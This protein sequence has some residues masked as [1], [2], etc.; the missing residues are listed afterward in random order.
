GIG[1]ST[2]DQAAEAAA[3][4]DGVIVGT[5]VVRRQLAGAGPDGVAAFVAELRAGLD[6]M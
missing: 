6:A 2:P 5:A 1:V 4:A 3:S